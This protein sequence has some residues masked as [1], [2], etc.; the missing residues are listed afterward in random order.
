[1][2]VGLDCHPWETAPFRPRFPERLAQR[3][4]SGGGPG[5]PTP[6][7]VRRG[8]PQVNPR[9]PAARNSNLLPEFLERLSSA[10]DPGPRK[11]GDRRRSRVIF[12]SN[13]IPLRSGGETHV[14]SPKEGGGSGDRRRRPAAGLQAGEDH[15]SGPSCFGRSAPG[16][17]GSG[18]VLHAQDLAG[19]PVKHRW[20][21]SSRERTHRRS[22][23]SGPSCPR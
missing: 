6:R 2:A 18:R 8:N 23:P 16:R 14:L 15:A 1:M 9:K 13:A 7:A 21:R 17:D 11:V 19:T 10:A 22:S 5:V 4:A 12:I 20:A 3:P